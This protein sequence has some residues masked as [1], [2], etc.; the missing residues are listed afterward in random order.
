MRVEIKLIRD[1]GTVM[2]DIVM[3]AMAAGG[4]EVAE[5]GP[6]IDENGRKLYGFCYLPCPPPR[7]PQDVEE[8]RRLWSQH[9]GA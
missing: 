8:F 5:M 9:F 6:I 1:D 7:D 3:N 2:Y 4:W